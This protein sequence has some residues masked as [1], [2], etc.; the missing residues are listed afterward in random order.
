M[1]SSSAGSLAAAGTAAVAGVQIIKESGITETTLPV[2][3]RSPA[4]VAVGGIQIA[5]ETLAYSGT[6]ARVVSLIAFGLV[7]AGLALG[8]AARSISKRSNQS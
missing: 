5:K 4:Q 7:G 1:S 2:V 8:L 6:N 3:A